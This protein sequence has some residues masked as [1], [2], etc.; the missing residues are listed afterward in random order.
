MRRL[1]LGAL[2]FLFALWIGEALIRAFFV[3]AAIVLIAYGIRVMLR[4]LEIFDRHRDD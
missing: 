1:G 3:V 4:A 2:L